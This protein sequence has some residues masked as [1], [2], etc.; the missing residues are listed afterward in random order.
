M[1]PQARGAA[2]RHQD[3]ERVVAVISVC[4]TF[5]GVVVVVASSSRL[6]RLGHVYCIV[7]STEFLGFEILK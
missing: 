7:C 1:R 2:F 3:P 5:T 4:V 6:T